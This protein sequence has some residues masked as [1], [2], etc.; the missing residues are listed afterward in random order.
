MD[1]VG[2]WERIRIEVEGDVT[3]TPAGQVIITITGVSYET[4]QRVGE[5]SK[6]TDG[7]SRFFWH[8]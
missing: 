3:E 1:L 6:G 7:C 4:F 8:E 2:S 5:R